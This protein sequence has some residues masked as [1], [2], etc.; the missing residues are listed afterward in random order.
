[1]AVNKK[2]HAAMMKKD[3]DAFAK[4][5]KEGVNSDFKYVEDGRSMNFDQM[6]ANMRQ[7]M[8]QMTKVTASDSK[9]VSLKEKGNSATAVMSHRMSGRMIGKDKKSHTT[10][11]SGISTDVFR[12]QGGQWKMARMSWKSQKMTMDG[13]PY[14]PSKMGGG[15]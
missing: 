4:I 9:I 13:K 5:V 12:K 2:L 1:M 7:G 11:F 8:S 10:S 15:K 14:D 6:V 3:T